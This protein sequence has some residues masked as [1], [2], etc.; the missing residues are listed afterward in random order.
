MSTLARLNDFAPG[1]LII[2]GDLD[3]EFNQLVNAL[4]GT[5]TNKNLVVKVADSSNPPLALDQ[6]SSGLIQEWRQNGTTKSKINNNGQF[7]SLITTGTSPL[8]VASTTK[9]SN[10]NADL[11]DGIDGANLAQLST[12]RSAFSVS[13]VYLTPPAATET[14][15]STG[16]YVVPNGGVESINRI[17]ISFYGGSHTSGGV[18]TFTIKRYSFS[19]G[20]LTD[21]GTVTLDN[22]NNTVNNVYNTT[23]GVE[24]SLSDGDQ[25]FLLLTTRSGT[26][27][28]QTVTVSI[29]GKKF[30]S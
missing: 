5:S 15:P 13:W 12:H 21:I 2:S 14:V 18:L 24:V 11:I 6:T 20:A 25:I 19:G 10:L 23:L 8:V 28:E 4:N 9:V 27:T 7:E 16:A 22:T 26:I 17:R 1:A 3:A 30:L 29:S